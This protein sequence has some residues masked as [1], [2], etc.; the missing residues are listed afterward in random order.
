MPR[1][2]KPEIKKDLYEN[3]FEI[4]TLRK[5]MKDLKEQFKSKGKRLKILLKK[6]LDE[7]KR[8]KKLYGVK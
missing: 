8:L 4:I 7:E 6:E 3:K 2:M 5:E 1:P